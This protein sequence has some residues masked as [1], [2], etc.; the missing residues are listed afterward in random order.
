[1]ALESPALVTD[2]VGKEGA[3]TSIKLAAR[4]DGSPMSLTHP[5]HGWIRFRRGGSHT[6]RTSANPPDGGPSW[7]IAYAAY[8]S[9]PAGWRI[10]VEDEEKFMRLIPK[11]RKYNI[12]GIYTWT[13]D[14][15][16]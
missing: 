16:P 2:R 5:E 11:L 7:R 8:L 14:I 15:H 13:Y 3:M 9:E 6:P 12:H 10:V 1:M 4:W